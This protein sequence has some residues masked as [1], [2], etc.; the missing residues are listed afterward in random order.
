[1]RGKAL[2]LRSLEATENI[3]ICQHK[4]RATATFFNRFELKKAVGAL[5]HVLTGLDLQR[6]DR[7]AIVM[8][9]R[10]EMTVAYMPLSMVFAPEA[11][12]C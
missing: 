7:V 10:F 9:Q 4:Q 8:P 2:W 6:G 1:M 12:G 5:H 3:A 11:P